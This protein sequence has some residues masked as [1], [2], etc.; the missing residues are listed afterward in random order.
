MRAEGWVARNRWLILAAV[1]AALA[2][3]LLRSQPSALPDG[4]L[5]ELVGAGEPVVVEFY[6]NT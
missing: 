1:A 5:M 4:G 6:S 3:S 2:Y